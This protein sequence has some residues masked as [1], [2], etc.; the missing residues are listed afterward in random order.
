MQNLKIEQFL[1]EFY[2]RMEIIERK[3]LLLE[4]FGWLICFYQAQA[5]LWVH[6][7]IFNQMYSVI[8][9]ALNLGI[10]KMDCK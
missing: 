5:D 6:S 3:N 4:S 7:S 8:S 1:G 2:G 10:D 9:I